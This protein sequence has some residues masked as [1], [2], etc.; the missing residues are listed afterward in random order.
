MRIEAGDHTLFVG[1]VLHFDRAEGQPLVFHSGAYWS[2]L[3]GRDPT[4]TETWPSFC[5]DPIGPSWPDGHWPS[6][7][8]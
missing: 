5:V 4:V 8:G 2:L 7:A 3:D 6:E 1:E